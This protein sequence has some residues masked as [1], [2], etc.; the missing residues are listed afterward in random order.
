VTQGV[1]KPGEG[2]DLR[3]RRVGVQFSPDGLN[4][5]GL[6]PEGRAWTRRAIG[7]LTAWTDAPDDAQEFP[8]LVQYVAAEAPDLKSAKELVVGYGNLAAHLLTRLE[9]ATGMSRA[10]ILQQ[11]AEIYAQEPED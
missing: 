1:G 4:P 3:P 8:L 10:D 11:L 7:A 6:N 2:A 5:A 9:Q